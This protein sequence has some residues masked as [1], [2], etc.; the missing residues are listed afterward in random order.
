VRPWSSKRFEEI[1]PR[2]WA[3][4]FAENQNPWYDRLRDE[5]FE[6]IGHFATSG[7]RRGRCRRAGS[8]RTAGAE[9]TGNLQ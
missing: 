1:N 4:S 9:V 7:P 8:A 5:K 3:K 6:T 2:R